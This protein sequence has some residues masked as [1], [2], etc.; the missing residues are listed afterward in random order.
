MNIPSYSQ[1]RELFAYLAQLAEVMS[2]DDAALQLRAFSPVSKGWAIVVHLNKESLGAAL[3]MPGNRALAR[4]VEGES[5]NGEDSDLVLELRDALQTINIGTHE[6][7]LNND[8]KSFMP[9]LPCKLPPFR[10]D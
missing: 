4:I 9:G 7:F 3:S 8:G 2:S 10:A 1:V 5:A 6:L